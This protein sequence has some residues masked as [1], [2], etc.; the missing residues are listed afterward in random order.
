MSAASE[1]PRERLRPFECDDLERVGSA[2][3]DGGYVVSR[4]SIDAADA[5]LSLGIGDDV[6]FDA[7][8]RR[9]RPQA[10]IIGCDHTIDHGKIASRYW[11]DRARSW[12]WPLVGATARGRRHGRR[13]EKMA[14]FGRLYTGR[15]ARAVHLPLEVATAPGPGRVTIDELVARAELSPSRRAFVKMDIEGAEYGTLAAV[16]AHAA[17][18]TGLAVEFHDLDRRGEELAACLDLL[19]PGFVLVHVHGNNCASYGEGIDFPTVVEGTFVGR[20]V[21][22]GEPTPYSGRLPRPGLDVPNDPDRMD[23]AV[24]I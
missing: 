8:F 13:A 21:M 24:R 7:E 17:C 9:R 22:A 20:G 11:R 14:G 18:F 4:R 15:D 10:T 1:F 16:A 12:M 2:W 3:G 6:T 23:L 19:A 5:L